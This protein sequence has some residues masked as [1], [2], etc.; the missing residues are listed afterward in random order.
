M[1]V[2]FT[3]TSLYDDLSLLITYESVIVSPN[4]NVAETA[5]AIDLTSCYAI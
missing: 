2:S 3:T 1:I 5:E 4:R